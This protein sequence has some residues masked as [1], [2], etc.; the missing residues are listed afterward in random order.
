MRVVLVLV[1]IL[2]LILIQIL[3]LIL[4]QIL[5]LVPVRMNDSLYFGS[6]LGAA[7]G[8]G[9]AGWWCGAGVR[10]SPLLPH[11]LSFYFSPPESD[12][13]QQRFRL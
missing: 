10:C 5:I 1:L 13:T 7:R 8:P 3:V 9:A 2:I 11:P 12:A 6:P 4:F